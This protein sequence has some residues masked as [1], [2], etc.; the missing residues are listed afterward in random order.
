M[1]KFTEE[2]VHLL[3]QCVERGLSYSDSLIYVGIPNTE[4]NRF[5]L[6]HIVSGK[7]WK[8]ISS[9]YNIDVNNKTIFNIND[10]IKVCEM[11][12]KGLSDMEIYNIINLG[13]DREK[14]IRFIQRI[15][16]KKAYTHVSNNY[17]F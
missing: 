7:R 16:N 5:N 13:F 15:R 14:V 2:Q 1:S 9:Q 11:I 4:N 8:H 3:C 12:E 17:N 6:S 10:A